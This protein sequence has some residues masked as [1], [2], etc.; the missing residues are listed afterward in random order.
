MSWGVI[1][2]A[3]ALSGVA[4][5]LWWVPAVFGISTVLA[6]GVLVAFVVHSFGLSTR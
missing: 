6:V 4:A 3:A 2:V 5:E 1:P